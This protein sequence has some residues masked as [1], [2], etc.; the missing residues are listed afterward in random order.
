MSAFSLL[1]LLLVSETVVFGD[2]LKALIERR[3]VAK[4]SAAH[5]KLAEK[6][7]RRG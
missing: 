6:R 5:L 7:L 2:R 4:R 1:V 3:R